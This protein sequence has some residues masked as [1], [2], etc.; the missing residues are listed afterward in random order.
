[1]TRSAAPRQARTVRAEGL[2]YEPGIYRS[3]VQS[4][5]ASA[6]ERSGSQSL[7]APTASS[8][9]AAAAACRRA[10]LQKCSLTRSIGIAVRDTQQLG[11]DGNPTPSSSSIFA[12]ETIRDAA[13]VD[14]T[15]PG[16]FPVTRKVD[17]FLSPRDQEASSVFDDRCDDDD[18]AK[19]QIASERD[20]P[21]ICLHV[22]SHEEDRPVVKKREI[23][24]F[25]ENWRR[26]SS[27][28]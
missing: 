5:S 9:P 4:T 14:R 1:M 12:F 6:G 7:A 20:L 24:S 11:S 10:M 16:E 27:T 17:A 23:A 22:I 19:S 3:A 18:E 15:C 2:R 21:D 28:G 13:R 8:V 26:L 25:R